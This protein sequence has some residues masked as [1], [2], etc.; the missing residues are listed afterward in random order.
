MCVIDRVNQLIGAIIYTCCVESWK[1]N[2]TM[3]CA[4]DCFAAI[5]DIAACVAG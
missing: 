4:F 5:F 1:K 3:F 2:N